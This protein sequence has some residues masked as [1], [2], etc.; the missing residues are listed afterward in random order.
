MNF[1]S[2]SSY[3]SRY[4][5]TPVCKHVGRLCSI[6]PLIMKNFT[7]HP[8]RGGDGGWKAR[9]SHHKIFFFLTQRLELSCAVIQAQLMNHFAIYTIGTY[10]GR[11]MPHMCVHTQCTGTYIYYILWAEYTL[12]TMFIT[13]VEKCFVSLCKSENVK[14]CI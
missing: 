14:N 13:V 6:V 8:K 10:L 9:L 5:C 4:L 11:K 12:C 3:L 2:L 1:W 7:L